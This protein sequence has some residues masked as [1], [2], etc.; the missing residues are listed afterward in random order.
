MGPHKVTLS[1]LRDTLRTSSTVIQ[2]CGFT[3]STDIAVKLRTEVCGQTEYAYVAVDIDQAVRECSHLDPLYFSERDEDSIPVPRV[4]ASSSLGTTSAAKMERLREASILGVNMGGDATPGSGKMFTPINGCCYSYDIETS[5]EDTPELGFPL[6]DARILSIAGVCSCGHE[7]YTSS[8]TTLHQSS[9][10]VSTFIADVLDHSPIWLTGWNCF[11]FDNECMRFQAPECVQS[12]FHVVRVGSASRPRYGSILN[13]PGTYNVDLYLYMERSMGHVFK[14]FKLSSV[15]EKLGTTLKLQMPAMGSDIDPDELRVYNMNDCVVVL[16]IW[17]KVDASLSIP[18]LALCMSSPVYDSARYTTG[19]MAAMSFSSFCISRGRVVAWSRCTKEQNYK[20]GLV[21]E[22]SRGK[23]E[24]MIVLDYK[25]MYPSVMSGCMISPCDI[26][27]KPPRDGTVEEGV[28][29]K[30]KLVSFLTAQAVF[31]FDS[32]KATMMGEF[33]NFL[34]VER[35]KYRK[36]LPSYAGVLKVSANSVYGALGYS[37]SPL[38]SPT[39]SAAVT[40][41]G[42][43]CIRRAQDVGTSCGLNV[44]YGDTDSCFVTSDGDQ[45]HL[46]AC[47]ERTLEK[48]HGEFENTCLHTMRLERELYYK[49]GILLD[50][51]RYCLMRTDNT[52]K[53]VGISPARQDVSGIL[54]TS[55]K[56][57]MTSLLELP[58]ND[59]GLV[60]SAYCDQLHNKGIREGFTLLEASRH[61]TRQGKKGYVY[62]SPTG[63]EV[64]IQEATADLSSVVAC[65]T[66]K[67]LAAAFKEIERFTKP[68]GLGSV[69]EIVSRHSVDL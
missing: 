18:S 55:A 31:T 44:V 11:G 10:L 47:V 23:W 34:I 61:V 46:E 64:F 2:W 3:P 63:G 12:Y 9:A 48:L 27:I 19:A 25:S 43:Y 20:G 30:G 50:K 57:A 60:I 15:A 52:I 51:K 39:C 17:N 54:K 68:C 35:D 53:S 38:Y 62:P 49:S 8:T 4:W 66:Q 65:N 36:T 21:L 45:R 7:F 26:D 28:E 1:Q 22:P 42:R 6:S 37:N 67:V 56:V 32:S 69:V 14:S 29:V 5:L 16:D 24:R 33:M 59:A 40:A 58:L 13:L 41:I